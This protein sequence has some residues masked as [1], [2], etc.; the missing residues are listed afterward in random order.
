MWFSPIRSDSCESSQF[1]LRPVNQTG[2][3][4]NFVMTSTAL[5]RL[6][7][8]TMRC[9]NHLWN[10]TYVNQGWML[11]LKKIYFLKLLIL[12]MVHQISNTHNERV[13]KE[14][15]FKNMLGRFIS[16][17]QVLG[18]LH[19]PHQS[20]GLLAVFP[21]NSYFHVLTAWS[22]QHPC[23]CMRVLSTDRPKPGHIQNPRM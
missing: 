20:Y 8:G 13:T 5:H 19:A 9:G 14:W 6:P 22:F 21:F 23:S 18:T 3:V 11:N 1:A 12:V 16:T 7:A 15:S 2:G 10:H 4:I 17:T